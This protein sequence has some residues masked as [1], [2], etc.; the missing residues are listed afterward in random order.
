[1]MVIAGERFALECGD[2]RFVDLGL[3]HGRDHAAED[4]DWGQPGELHA[5]VRY[6]SCGLLMVG[7][8]DYFA[9]ELRFQFSNSS[10]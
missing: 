8:A 9:A 6:F 4:G 7:P 10:R 2:L 3:V 1:M 5:H